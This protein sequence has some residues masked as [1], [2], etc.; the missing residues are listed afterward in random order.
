MDLFRRSREQQ[1]RALQQPSSKWLELAVE[2]EQLVSSAPSPVVRAALSELALCYT[3]FA[4][5]LDASDAFHSARSQIRGS[6]DSPLTE[7]ERSE[8]ARALELCLVTA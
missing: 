2:V 5:G 8:A 3:A 1:T 7:D 4:A 6:G